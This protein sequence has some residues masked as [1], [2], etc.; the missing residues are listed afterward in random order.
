[1]SWLSSNIAG[2]LS[3]AAGS[4][5]AVSCD[6]WLPSTAA[7]EVAGERLS[8]GVPVIQ[9]KG[10]VAKHNWHATQRQ[11]PPRQESSEAACVV[12]AGLRRAAGGRCV[13]SGLRPRRTSYKQS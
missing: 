7:T 10:D 13:L 3:A 5:S 1:M 12:I 8:L 6:S 4:T 9:P 11:S 2:V